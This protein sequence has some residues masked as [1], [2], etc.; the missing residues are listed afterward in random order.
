MD[1][2]PGCGFVGAADDP[3]PTPP[4]DRHSSGACWGRYEEL[5][6]RSYGIAAY[7]GVHQLVVDVYVAQ[8]PGGDS[9]TEIQRLALCLMTL[10]LFVED[11]V[12]VRRGAELHKR[13]MA[14]RPDYFHAL[15]PPPLRGMLTAADVLTAPDAAEHE[16]LVRAWGEQVWRAWRPHHALIRDWNARALGPMT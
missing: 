12:D 10:C 2:C 1:E 9:R 15:E 3:A 16:R 11:D 6:A 13:M 14:D 4:A 7:R 8:H 5:L